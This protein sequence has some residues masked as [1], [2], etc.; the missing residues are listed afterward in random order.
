MESVLN[1]T[2]DQQLSSVADLALLAVIVELLTIEAIT[3]P[4]VFPEGF[5]VRV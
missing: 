5:V 4:K 3:N 2:S 1:T